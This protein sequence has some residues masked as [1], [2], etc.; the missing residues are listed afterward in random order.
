ML[1]SKH[2]KED[3]IKKRCKTGFIKRLLVQVSTS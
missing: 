1:V 2:L 3:L